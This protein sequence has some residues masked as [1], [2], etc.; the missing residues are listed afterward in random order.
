LRISWVVSVSRQHWPVAPFTEH[1]PAHPRPLT[2]HQSFFILMMGAPTYL[3]W[4]M[5]K[6]KDKAQTIPHQAFLAQSHKWTNLGLK[7]CSS[8]F[9]LCSLNGGIPRMV[10][11]VLRLVEFQSS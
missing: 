10:D 4:S 11:L 3:A 1:G 2:S 6:G 5:L 8:T 7:L 9:S